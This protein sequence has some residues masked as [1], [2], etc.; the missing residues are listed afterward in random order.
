[1]IESSEKLNNQAVTLA[2]K[3]QFEEA[4]L[5]FKRAITVE[6]TN[7]LLWYNLG[8]TYRDNGDL[9]NAKKALNNALLLNQDSA[10]VVLAV[11]QIN[12]FQK[13]YAEALRIISIGLENFENDENMWN[14]KGTILFNLSELKQACECFENALIINPYYYDALFNLRDTYEKLGNTVGA[15]ECSNKL[16][17]LKKGR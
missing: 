3:G 14:L 17:S 16:K 4:I 13:D 15:E 5:C 7:Y 1:M 9:E 2:S 6:N 11:S 12:F 10:E 8:L